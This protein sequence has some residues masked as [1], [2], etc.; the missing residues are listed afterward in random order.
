MNRIRFLNLLCDRFTGILF[1]DAGGSITNDMR[2]LEDQDIPVHTLV[3]K[4][5]GCAAADGD[6]IDQQAYL[7]AHYDA[8]PGTYYL[9]RPDQHVAARWR[10]FDIARVNQALSRATGHS[11]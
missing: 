11:N 2:T 6:I 7:Q 1:A 5:A 10:S 4:P 8:R 3:V 9:I